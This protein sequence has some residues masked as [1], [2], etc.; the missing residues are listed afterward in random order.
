MAN[1]MLKIYMT[2]SS[3][4]TEIPAYEAVVE[5]NDIQAMYCNA[6]VVEEKQDWVQQI[7]NEDPNLFELSKSSCYLESPVFFR[8]TINTLMGHF[9]QSEGIHIIQCTGGCEL[10]KETGELTGFVKFGYDGEDLLEFDLKGQKWIALR[11]DALFLKELWDTDKAEIIFI[12]EL[13]TNACYQWLNESLISGNNTLLRTDYPSV[14]LLQKTASSPVRCH[15][16]GFYPKTFLMF[17]AKDEE[18][19]HEG[20]EHGDVLPNDDN[21][22]KYHVDLDIL[23]IPPEDWKRYEC[24]FQFTGAEDRILTKLDEAVIETNRDSEDSP[25]IRIIII[26]VISVLI[27]IIIIALGFTACKRENERPLTPDSENIFL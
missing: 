22:F 1:H 14:A 18:E 8:N 12:T 26:V 2:G 11:E 19:I 5:V 6:K 10:N 21:T 13:T 17:W 27:V 15:A 23:S 20:V 16:T 9:N 25:Q 4:L 7:F 3:G 24:V